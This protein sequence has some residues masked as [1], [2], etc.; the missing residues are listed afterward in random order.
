MIHIDIKCLPKETGT[1]IVGG[2]VRDL[3]L[4]RTPADYDIAVSGNPE[5]YAKKLAIMSNGHWVEL[6]KDKQ[7]IIRVSAKNRLYDITSINGSCI[8]EDLEQRDFTINALAYDISHGKIIDVTGGLS[9]IADKKIRMVS[10]FVFQNDPVRLFRA[11]RIGATFNFEIDPE[12]CNAIKKDAELIKNT[13]GER[14]SSEFFKLLSTT[15]SYSYLKQMAETS[16]L[17]TI[18]PEITP[19][20]GCRQN[21]YHDFDVYGHTMRSYAYLENIINNPLESITPLIDYIRSRK[22]PFMPAI[23]KCAMLFHDLGKPVT[24]TTDRDNHIHFY[25][26]ATR[27]AEIAADIGS[28]LRFS[29]LEKTYLET[30]IHYH[31]RPLGLFNAYCQN[32]L[33]R[34]T[35]TRFF[36]KFNELTPDLLLHFI[37][38]TYGKQKG[39][40]AVSGAHIRFINSIFENY[41]KN[42]LPKKSKK[43]LISGNDL[44]QE[45]GLRPSPLFSEI[46]HHVE[47][48]RLSGKITSRRDA[49]SVASDMAKKS[50]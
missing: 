26:H 34:R 21:R 35:I 2:P 49:I 23:L 15:D 18:F 8:Q 1:Y 9:D 14:I 33:T 19:L 6:G 13:A 3:L 42:Y 4:G 40:D 29:N 7:K 20:A 5:E 25:R 41:I 22:K 46:L 48:E 47:E 44:M 31:L 39:T 50:T 16:L 36:M 30:I 27:G 43:P 45:L 37:A 28:R 11:F 10:K 17:F 38:D 12:T 24:R 32:E